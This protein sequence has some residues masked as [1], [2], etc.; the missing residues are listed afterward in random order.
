VPIE[1]P[2]TSRPE[3]LAKFLE[4]LPSVDVPPGEVG[5]AYF[6]TLGFSAASGRH[7]LEILKILGFVGA[8]GM[9]STLW[10]EYVAA[11][12][13]GLV[14]AA[15]VKKAYAEFFK[16]VLCPYLEDDEVILDFLKR[17]V[18]ASPRDWELMLQTFRTLVAPA[19]F[20]DLLC[21]DNDP[22]PAAPVPESL[23]AAGIKVN[24]NLQVSIQVHIDPST[25]D[26]KIETIFKNMRKYLLGKDDLTDTTTPEQ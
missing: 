18:E 25:P 4:I 21:V 2:C 24:P 6:K 10:P 12:N 8:S 16:E 22:A 26:E 20:Q 7:L 17:N 3:D 1:V 23:P 14:L 9:P 11:A 5:T 13:K 19:D 15:A